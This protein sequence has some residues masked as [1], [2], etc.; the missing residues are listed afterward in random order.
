MAD[1][2]R[3]TSRRSPRALPANIDVNNQAPPLQD[4]GPLPQV[5]A[6][7]RPSLPVEGDLSPY[8]FAEAATFLRISVKTLRKMI[9]RGE[10]PAELTMRTGRKRWMTG[11]QIR[12]AILHCAGTS[13]APAPDPVRRRPRRAAA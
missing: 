2:H 1:A 9:D 3:R 8:T 11:D 10:I 4:R 13:A 5:A 7:V 12:R 6:G